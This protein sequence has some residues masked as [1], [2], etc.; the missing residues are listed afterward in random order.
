MRRAFTL[1][2]LLVVVAIIA[3]LAALLFP[4]FARAR[5]SARRTAC[6]SNLRQIGQAVLLYAQDA[7]EVLPT[8]CFNDGYYGYPPQ[9]HRDAR[10]HPIVMV[11]LLRPYARATG[12]F[13]CP[14]MRAQP[15]RAAAYRTD[16]NYLCAHGWRH[17]PGFESF[18]NDLQGVCEHPLAAIGRSASKPMVV[19]DGLGEHVGE[20]TNSVYARGK[21]GAQNIAYVDGHVKLTPGTFADIVGLYMAPNN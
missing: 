18:D 8:A 13:L 7:D 21:L 2:E 9:T 5:E 1:I 10:G 6:T 16:Y 4:V 19:C 12:L 14:T 17:V 3:V 15:G 11:D 20:T